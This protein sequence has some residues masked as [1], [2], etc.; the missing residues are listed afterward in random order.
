MSWAIGKAQFVTCNQSKN[1]SNNQHVRQ[2]GKFLSLF[3]VGEVCFLT[4]ILPIFA[5]IFFAVL[6]IACVAAKPL[7]PVAAYSAYSAPV[8][9]ASPALA[10]YSAPVAAAYTAAAYTAASPYAVS[11]YAVAPYAAAYSAY[12]YAAGYPYAATAAL[13]YTSLVL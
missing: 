7:F 2:S 3:E 11:P 10:A 4:R 6:A 13:P 1:P 8:V 9:A 12:P 5:Q